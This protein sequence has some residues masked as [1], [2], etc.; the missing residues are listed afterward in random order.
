MSFRPLDAHPERAFVTAGVRWP[1]AEPATPGVPGG[2]V[3]SPAKAGAALIPASAAALTATASN[4]FLRITYL[5]VSR[6]PVWR[7][8]ST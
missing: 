8:F 7:R 3:I 1:E 6:R 2:P 4:D 5:G